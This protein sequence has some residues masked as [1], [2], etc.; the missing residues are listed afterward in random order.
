MPPSSA[1]ILVCRTCSG[2]IPAWSCQW[3]RR[4]R[5]D[6]SH[7]PTNNNQMDN[8]QDR[9][10]PWCRESL[11]SYPSRRWW[12]RRTRSSKGSSCSSS[13]SSSSSFQFS[14]SLHQRASAW[15]TG[16]M[17]QWCPS[18]SAY[19]PPTQPLENGVVKNNSRI[20]AD[21]S[22]VSFPDDGTY[23]SEMQRSPRYWLEPS[24]TGAKSFHSCT[25]PARS[26]W[27]GWTWPGCWR[28]ACCL[29][30]G[31]EA[32]GI[33]QSGQKKRIWQKQSLI[34]FFGNP[35]PPYSWSS[36]CDE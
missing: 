21:C 17:R 13:R 30:P 22:P 29:L 35:P 8:R 7:T 14:C 25:G 36:H 26:T 9:T 3:D 10:I 5:S 28:D 23:L 1:W 15:R 24:S 2:S 27:R 12:T 18:S 6:R 33:H 34:D 31:S 20:S 19:A 4:H 32:A 11:S 16:R